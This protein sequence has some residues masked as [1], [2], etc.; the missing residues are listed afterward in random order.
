MFTT[1]RSI[2]LGAELSGL[3]IY[4]PGP[5]SQSFEALVYELLAIIEQAFTERDTMPARSIKKTSM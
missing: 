1:A 3:I 4:W 2:S 5:H